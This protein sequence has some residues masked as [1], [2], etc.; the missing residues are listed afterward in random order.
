MESATV[1]FLDQFSL[2]TL[3]LAALLVQLVSIEVGYRM[4]IWSQAHAAK[5]Q[6]S[7]V[8]SI[9][10]AGLGLLAFML[11]FTFASSQAHYEMRVQAMVD[12]TRLVRTAYLQAAFL[13][14][15]V[16]DEARSILRQ[17]ASDRLG[18]ESALRTGNR[19]EVFR[20]LQRAEAMQQNLWD[21]AIHLSELQSQTES[22]EGMWNGFHASVLGLIDAHVARVQATA[23][24]RIP[25]VLWMALMLMAV[26]SMVVMGYQAGLVGRRSPM[27][28]ITLAIAFATVM[29][30]ITDLDRPFNTL[31][32]MDHQIM[33]NLV[34]Q[35]HESRE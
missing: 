27:A 17:Y 31:F 11:A 5:A 29:V 22:Q 14:D 26:L 24:N 1:H 25:D 2:P 21:L 6:A 19:E 18:I 32:H 12:E 3:F 30:L 9:M 4:G 13:P 8:R 7:Q 34:E 23:L 20:I 33:A 10:G 15:P 35:M 28:T 16:S